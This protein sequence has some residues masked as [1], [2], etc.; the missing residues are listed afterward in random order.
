MVV[1]L[2]NNAIVKGNYIFWLILN[3]ERV[4]LWKNICCYNILQLVQIYFLNDSNNCKNWWS[5][6]LYIEY[7]LIVPFQLQLKSLTHVI[8]WKTFEQIFHSN[9]HKCVEKNNL[10]K[11]YF[12]SKD[13]KNYVGVLCI[14]INFICSLKC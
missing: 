12:H 13:D 11:N 1:Q 4:F 7:E 6:L 9:E 10:L 3:D 5:I 2:P 14:K 8:S